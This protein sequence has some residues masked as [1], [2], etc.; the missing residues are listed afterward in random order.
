[1]P[2]EKAVKKLQD[3]DRSGGLANFRKNLRPIL[4]V[5]PDKKDWP[6]KK[7]VESG[8]ALRGWT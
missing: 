8:N 5:P 1:M 6:A 2:K 4:I 3:E 7:Y